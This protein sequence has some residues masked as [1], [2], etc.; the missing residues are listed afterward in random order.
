MGGAHSN[1]HRGCRAPTGW[2]TGTMNSQSKVS[3]SK[4]ALSQNSPLHR[5]KTHH[6]VFCCARHIQTCA[7]ALGGCAWTYL[8]QPIAQALQQRDE[9]QEV[10][11]HPRYRIIIMQRC[12]RQ[13]VHTPH[14]CTWGSQGRPLQQSLSTLQAFLAL[15]HC[16]ISV[17]QVSQDIKCNP[18]MF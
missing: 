3:Q 18:S 2:S 16:R 5:K 4:V 11:M 10:A 17:Q 8:C 7:V 6:H 12:K 13:H 15:T 1:P 9:L 14:S